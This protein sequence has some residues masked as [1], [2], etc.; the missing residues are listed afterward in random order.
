VQ[1]GTDAV[2]ARGSG[3]GLLNP[4]RRRVH[5]GDDVLDGPNVVGQARRH[6]WGRPH[7]LSGLGERLMRAAIGVIQEEQA[8]R[9]RV[10][11]GLF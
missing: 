8:D 10:V 4:S 1:V 3:V 9:V 2:K 7:A 11:L 5:Q 6:R